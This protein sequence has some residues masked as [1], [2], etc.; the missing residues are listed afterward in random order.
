MTRARM[1]N[2]LTF[3]TSR[4]QLLNRNCPTDE[5]ARDT[6]RHAI[7]VRRDLPSVIQMPELAECCLQILKDAKS[8][9]VELP[10]KISSAN[11]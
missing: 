4:C 11:S 9:K 1:N 6:C 5:N 10:D 8:G 3:Q 2:G 7:E